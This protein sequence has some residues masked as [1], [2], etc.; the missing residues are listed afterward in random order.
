MDELAQFLCASF[1]DSVNEFIV[2]SKV[3]CNTIVWLKIYNCTFKSMESSGI[4]ENIIRE[5]GA[6]G[7]FIT[8][9][10]RLHYKYLGGRPNTNPV[11]VSIF[12]YRAAWT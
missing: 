2:L 8:Q 12:D 6:V 1:L 9:T 10:S 11:I 3:S 5:K 4:K 7:F